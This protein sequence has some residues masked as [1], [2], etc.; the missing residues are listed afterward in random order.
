MDVPETIP[1]SDIAGLQVRYT[2]ATGRPMM[3]PGGRW[4]PFDNEEKGHALP[5]ALLTFSRHNRHNV[6]I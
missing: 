3:G 6:Q 4:I 1:M 5:P 2:L